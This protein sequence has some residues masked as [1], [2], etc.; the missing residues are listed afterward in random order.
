MD[1]FTV[2][3]ES[4]LLRLY[5]TPGT[6]ITYE[7]A[8]KAARA[9][10]K[11]SGGHRMPLLVNAAG[12]TGLAPEARAGMNAYR[13]FSI[14]ALLGD[15]PVGSV[16]TAFARQSSTPTRYFSDENDALNWLIQHNGHQIDADDKRKL[17]SF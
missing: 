3:L 11:L 12:V 14:T 8:V 13:G 10:E 9:L 1:D 6:F 17:G 2:S 7:M 4:G 5:W 16:L 15:E